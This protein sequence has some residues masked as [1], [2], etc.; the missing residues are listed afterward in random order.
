V[1]ATP[2]EFDIVLYGATGFVGKLTAEYLARARAGA[3]IALAGRSPDRLRAVRDTLSESARDWPVLTADAATPS[4]LDEMAA[5]TRV[6]VTTVGPYTRYGLPLVAACATAGTDYADLT[7]EPPFMRDSIDLYHKQAADTGAR[8]VH[9]CGFDSIPSDLSVYALYRA[10]QRDGAGELADT[11]FVVRSLRGGFSGGTYAS[12]LEVLHTASSN[13]DAR[14][15]LADPYTLSTDRGAEPEFGRQPDLASRR[16]G[17][18]APELSG[19]WTA[20]FLMAPT[21]TRIVRR[22][23]ALLDWAYG[24]RFRYDENMSL[25]SSALAPVASA[26]LGGVGNAMFELGSRYFRL[27]PRRLVE[28]VLPKPG[29]GPSAEARDRGYYRTETYTTTTTGARYVARMEQ[30]GDPGYKATSVL[31]GEC[32]L[33]LALDR[34]KLSDLLGVLTPAAAMGDV[35]LSRFPAAGVSLGVDRLG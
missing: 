20:G 13:P 18:L 35:L 32:G 3:R 27:L 29:T 1:T 24:R 17:H 6:V 19:L 5:R 33:A 10:A 4:T 21:N 16:G 22:S 2:R 14:R 31:L 7:G 28:R 34:D 12:L 26:V 11:H 25:G 9:A 15:Q 30:R 8:I 23:N